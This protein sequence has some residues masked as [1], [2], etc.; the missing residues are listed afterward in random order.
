MNR[1]I[2][3]NI[4]MATLSL[5]NDSI[6]QYASLNAG[7]NKIANEVNAM[8]S[9]SA[10]STRTISLQSKAWILAPITNTTAMVKSAR[11][12]F[13]IGGFI[14]NRYEKVESLRCRS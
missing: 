14:G 8:A 1:K 5:L 6:S 10:G 4:L 13:F 12:C 11:L 9:S 3:K 7:L 2:V